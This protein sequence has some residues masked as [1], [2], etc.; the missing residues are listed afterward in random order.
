METDWKNMS[1]LAYR[2]DALLP[3]GAFAARAPGN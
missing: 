3:S 1:R 2:K